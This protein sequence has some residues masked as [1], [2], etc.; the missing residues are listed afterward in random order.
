MSRPAH[1]VI[2]IEH[3][4]PAGMDVALKLLKKKLVKEGVISLLKRDSR[5]QVAMSP[6]QKKRAK[7]ARALRLVRRRASR[8]RVRE[9][10]EN[11]RNAYR[12]AVADADHRGRAQASGRVAA[13]ETPSPASPQAEVRREVI[14]AAV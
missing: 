10:E 6:S 14:A 8:Q 5:L 3:Q 1:A 2:T 4:G 9:N 13:V 11:D 12:R 7:R